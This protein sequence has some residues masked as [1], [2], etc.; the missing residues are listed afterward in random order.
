MD[1]KRFSS[2]L[3]TAYSA[4]RSSHSVVFYL[5][6]QRGAT[7]EV[8]IPEVGQPEVR[9]WGKSLEAPAESRHSECDETLTRRTRVVDV[10]RR[11][12]EVQP[13]VCNRATDSAHPPDPSRYGL[14]SARRF[15]PTSCTRSHTIGRRE[16][17]SGRRS[18][19]RQLTPSTIQ[20]PRTASDRPIPTRREG[21]KESPPRGRVR[22]TR[23]PPSY[24][25]SERPSL[26]S[27]RKTGNRR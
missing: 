7:R 4:S 18:P 3:D 25:G 1:G 23:L 5:R 27:H 13:A 8:A 17:P 19:V 10:V 16:L 2:S 20:A 24:P 11:L 22:A 14:A 12:S 15:P 9:I 6:D 26:K 21:I